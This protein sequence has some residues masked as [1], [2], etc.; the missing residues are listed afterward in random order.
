V[1][2]G[3]LT[4]VLSG[5]VR[6]RLNRLAWRASYRQKRYVGS[7]PTLSAQYKESRSQ[8]DPDRLLF[9]VARRLVMESNDRCLFD[10]ASALE[11]LS[12]LPLL[13][14]EQQ[15]FVLAL[16][17]AAFDTRRSNSFV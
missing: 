6:E 13:F 2:L 16:S 17:G 8:H 7:N 14:F 1:S 4:R 12:R 15:E 5:K 10:E 9:L 11:L 3:T